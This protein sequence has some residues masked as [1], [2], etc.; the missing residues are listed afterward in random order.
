ME[1]CF[2]NAGSIPSS[3]LHLSDLFLEASLDRPAHPDLAFVLCFLQTS[4]PPC[5]HT[6][7]SPL[8]HSFDKHVL[9]IHNH[10]P[11]SYWAYCVPRWTRPWTFSASGG[12]APVSHPQTLSWGDLPL[13][14]DGDLWGLSPLCSILAPDI[15]TGLLP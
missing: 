1:R 9:R 2:A 10:L 6:G 3:I 14:S 13:H 15:Y 5:I 8:V 11:G 7:W 4:Y 12:C